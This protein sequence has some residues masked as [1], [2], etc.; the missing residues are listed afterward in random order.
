MISVKDLRVEG[1][2]KVPCFIGSTKPEF[3]WR[4]EG[5][6]EGVFQSAYRIVVASTKEGLASPDLWDSGKVVSGEQKFIAYK[7]HPL[8]ARSRLFFQVTVWDDKG[9]QSTNDPVGEAEVALL[10]NSDW[11]A[12]WIYFD[13]NNETVSSPCPYFRREFPV[14]SG[15]TGARLYIGARGVYEAYLN[16]KRVGEDVLVPGWTD[17]HKQIQYLAY[18]VTSLLQEGNNAAGVILGDGWYCGQLC[19]RNRA[20]YGV[21]HPEL[22]CQL[23]ISYGDG[24]VETIVSGNEWKCTTGP[25]LYSDLYDGE[26]Y[27]A[28]FE[29]GDW[30][31][32]G[33]D[34]SDWRKASVGETTA[35]CPELVLKC[36]PPV[37]KVR[38]LRPVQ[39]FH[40]HPDVTVWDFGQNFAG[41]VRIKVKGYAGYMFTLHFAEM[42]YPDNSLYNINYRGAIVTD[43]YVCHSG[44]NYEIAEQTWEPR[45]TFHGFR[46]VQIDGYQL[47]GQ[48]P[49]D[50]EVVGVAVYSDLED[51]S[52]FTC[53]HEELTRLYKNVVWG[54]RSN[55]LEIPTDCPQRD[56]RLG[57]TG[58]AEIFVET[59]CLNMNVDA[60]FRKWLRDMRDDQKPNGAVARIVPDILE[61]SEGAAAWA[62]AMVI[63]PWTIYRRYGDKT[64]LRDNYEAMKAWIQYQK[65]TSNALVRQKTP[66]GDWLALDKVATPTELVGTAYFALTSRLLGKMAEVLGYPED[67]TYYRTLG[68]DVAAAFRKE[69]LD[70]TGMLKIQS[71]TACALSLEFDLLL[72]EQRQGIADLLE[73]LIAENKGC[74]ATGF[75]GTG[76]LLQALTSVGNLDRAYSLLLQKAYP[77]WLFPVLQGA[78]TIWER[79]NSF[80]LDNG[81]GDV[82]MNSFNHYSYGA[83]FAWM[84]AVV[85]GIDYVEPA[86]KVIRFAARPNAEIGHASFELNTP[87]GKASSAWEIKGNAV[88]WKISAPAN[89]KMQIVLPKGVKNAKLNGKPMKQEMVELPNGKYE[90]TW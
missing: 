35:E 47:L 25:I 10:E 36:C 43:R 68:D 61:G 5:D 9:E 1:G 71:Q 2:L 27:D 14:R 18:D 13:G 56:E 41:W 26:F 54:Q 70:E 75:V 78:T 37:R 39:M 48:K 45:F 15:M 33:Y 7:G 59:A 83:V 30:N 21:G 82:R 86:G 42:L 50:V 60:F 51:S 49:E 46:Y 19:G 4:I 34:D 72:P 20:R 32:V 58:D 22:L 79:W 65:E 73:K 40:P 11:D 62:D 89:T 57:W 17:F 88:T 85:G 84:A 24:T 55:F 23:E 44:P 53:G 90:V 6:G 8:H 16:G 29:L 77:S 80:T 67:A 63:I 76:C 81:F 66:Y 74:L 31:V 3:S 64:L 38:E 12:Q 28:R 69:Y 87:Y 52:T